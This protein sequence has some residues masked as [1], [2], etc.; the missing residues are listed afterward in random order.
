MDRKEKIKNIKRVLSGEITINGLVEGKKYIVFKGLDE[1][2]IVEGSD[3]TEEG[4]KKWMEKRNP[5][6]EVVIFCE[7]AGDRLDEP[8]N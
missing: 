4:F 1:P 6:D 3:M 2:Y 5:K 8:I 7:T